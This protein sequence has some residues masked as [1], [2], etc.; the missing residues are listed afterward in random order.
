MV[1][2]KE[3][4]KRD[5]ARFNE[6]TALLQHPTKN[7]GKKS[8]SKITAKEARGELQDLEWR[9]DEY[10]DEKKLEKSRV[11][12][13]DID[14]IPDI[15]EELNLHPNKNLSN[16]EKAIIAKMG[17]NEIKKLDKLQKAI[18]DQSKVIEQ[19]IKITTN[20]KGDREIEIKK[21]SQTEENL[22]SSPKH[23]KNQ[24]RHR[25]F[26]EPEENREDLSEDLKSKLK[27]AIMIG[28]AGGSRKII[29]CPHCEGKMLA[30]GV[31][32]AGVKKEQSSAQK[33]WLDHI[34]KIAALPEHKGLPRPKVVKIA[35]VSW[36]E[37]KANKTHEGVPTT[38]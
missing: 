10:K 14:D 18:E 13:I 17:E 26:Y 16:E 34:K 9:I 4:Y 35:A 2:T 3:K 30:A 31:R 6:L 5:I 36:K 8:G 11:P 15:I 33:A 20:A 38:Y 24:L 19:E 21:T 32:A 37:E 23:T 27:N 12:D 28:K 29:Q 22:L 7:F 1:Y 25:K